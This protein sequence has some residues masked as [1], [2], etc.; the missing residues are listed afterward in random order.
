MG[1]NIKDQY[2]TNR[3]ALYCADTTEA[4]GGGG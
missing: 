4:I 1:I 2:I 3:Y